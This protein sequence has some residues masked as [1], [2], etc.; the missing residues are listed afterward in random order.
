METKIRLSSAAGF[1][2]RFPFLAKT[3]KSQRF[4]SYTNF[5]GVHTS[6]WTAQ[7]TVSSYGHKDIAL[8]VRIAALLALG[9]WMTEQ[10][11]RRPVDL[12]EVL[13]P[14]LLRDDHRVGA[15]KLARDNGYRGHEECDPRGHDSGPDRLRCGRF[16]SRALNHLGRRLVNYWVSSLVNVRE[17]FFKVRL[18]ACSQSSWIYLTTGT[19]IAQLLKLGLIG[20]SS[21]ES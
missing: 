6:T 13:W 11:G 12:G 3:Q 15:T 7:V 10:P 1:V 17:S 5:T 14:K 4:I 16:N 8:L 18:S 20:R 19:M 9:Q 21:D 2:R